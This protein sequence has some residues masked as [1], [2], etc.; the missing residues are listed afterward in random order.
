[1]VLAEIMFL[2]TGAGLIS[3]SSFVQPLLLSA[4]LSIYFFFFSSLKHI[5]EMS[6]QGRGIRMPR[7]LVN[8]R[9]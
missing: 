2:K 3:G 6:V 7:L 4:E 5:P 8:K 1:M 9:L